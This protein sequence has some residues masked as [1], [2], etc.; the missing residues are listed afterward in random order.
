MRLHQSWEQAISHMQSHFN[1]EEKKEAMSK[2]LAPL[3]LNDFC[4]PHKTESEALDDYIEIF[5]KLLAMGLATDRLPDATTRLLKSGCIPS[6]W[7]KLALNKLTRP[8]RPNKMRAEFYNAISI[9]EDDPP[10]HKSS[11]IPN[12]LE[13]D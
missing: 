10:P 13:D 12:L 6:P 2:Q 9:N 7:L 4:K 3:R 1:S 5:D 8:Y 11:L